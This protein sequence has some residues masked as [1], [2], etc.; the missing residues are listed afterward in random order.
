VGLVNGVGM[1]LVLTL[2]AAEI[3]NKGY[4]IRTGKRLVKIIGY[5]GDKTA[6]LVYG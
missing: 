6:M 4:G 3:N 1:A 2:V 5:R